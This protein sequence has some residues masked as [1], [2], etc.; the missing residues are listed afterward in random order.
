MLQY[1]R[2]HLLPCPLGFTGLLFLDRSVTKGSSAFLVGTVIYAVP[3][4]LLGDAT[5]PPPPV[6]AP[7]ISA[8][9]NVHCLN[10]LLLPII[11]P[12]RFELILQ[13]P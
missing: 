2:K 13:T 3:C 7:M 4:Q 5:P 10:N 6:L 8:H 9:K 1:L 12:S 11:I